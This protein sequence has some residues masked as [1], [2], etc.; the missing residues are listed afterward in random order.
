MILHALKDM[1]QNCDSAVY[2]ICDDPSKVDQPFEPSVC[3]LLLKFTTEESGINFLE[4]MFLSEDT[5]LWTEGT[6][7][8][9]VS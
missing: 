6:V 3:Q 8:H 2:F 9:R 7:F 5:K 4:L 1:L